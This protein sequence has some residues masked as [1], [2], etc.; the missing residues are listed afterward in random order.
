MYGIWGLFE[1]LQLRVQHFLNIKK[2]AFKVVQ[3]K[4]LAIITDPK[5]NLD[6]FTVGILENIFMENDLC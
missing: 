4:L 3:I 6:I 5:M 1:N 2:I